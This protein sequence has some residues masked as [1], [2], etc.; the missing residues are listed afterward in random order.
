M[1]ITT[2]PSTGS[3]IDLSKKKKL[4]FFSIS[5]PQTSNGYI[6]LHS[7]HQTYST[8]LLFLKLL[9]TCDIEK[10][11]GSAPNFKDKF[12]EKFTWFSR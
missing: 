7:K 11:H 9:N 12:W 1:S 8:R 2:T 6:P 10:H 5:T 4:S 3:V